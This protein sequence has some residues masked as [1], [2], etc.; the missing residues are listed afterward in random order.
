MQ[1]TNIKGKNMESDNM[2]GKKILIVYYSRTGRTKKL[3]E[4][5]M[6]MFSCDIEEI[7][8]IKP[9]KGIL[10]FL[11]GR[12]DAVL[13]NL[14]PIKKAEL[15]PEEYD[16]IILGSPVWASHVTPA[17]RTYIEQYKDK[18]RKV[19]FFCTHNFK[20]VKAVKIFND[21]ELLCGKK[22]IG[23]MKVSLKDLESNAIK[24]KLAIFKA[25]IINS[26]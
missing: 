15:N 9:G 3:A 26:N 24:E 18:F 17:V 13:K 12:K 7:V 21:M 16:I 19:A 23:Q 25:E 8:D 2:G 11:S 4:N 5:L 1:A 22:P 6:T 20:V 14:T 10:T